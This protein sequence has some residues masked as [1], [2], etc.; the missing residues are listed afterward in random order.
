MPKYNTEGWIDD[1]ETVD[2]VCGE[3]EQPFFGDAAD[4]LKGYGEGKT[5]L[6]YKSFEKINI[7]NYVR[8]QGSVGSCT[9]ASSAG[10]I[11]LTKAIEIADGERSEFQALTS[12]E[13]IYR[14]ARLNSRIS[15]DGAVVAL[16]IKAMNELG[17]LAM[18]KYGNIDLTKYDVDRCRKWGNNSGYPKELDIEAKKHTIGQF[19]QIRSYEEARDSIA[20]G[21]GIVCGSN[22]GYSSVC[23]KDGFAKQDTKWSH[24][25]YWAAC[26][27]D[28]EGILVVNSWGC[29]SDDTEV[30]TNH[31]WKLFKDLEVLDKIATL[32]SDNK[33]EFQF[34]TEYQ[35]YDNVDK[36]YNFKGR[37][38]DLLVTNN[39]NMYCANT[40]KKRKIW[41]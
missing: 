20:A 24:A 41:V 18:L 36:L 32:N 7:A 39:H 27:A 33:L 14:I 38:I 22:Y 10:L 31:G 15:G 13:H 34:P 4:N 19:S 25:M 29:Y 17:T 8:N 35:K 12:I 1:P 30:L 28:K 21:Y 9:A 16:A 3:L 37:N 26:R 40:R 2:N 11:D 6:L 23:D 5:V